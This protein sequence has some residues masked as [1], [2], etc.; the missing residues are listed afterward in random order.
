MKTKRGRLAH[1]FFRLYNKAHEIVT[2]KY[3]D[4]ILYNIRVSLNETFNRKLFWGYREYVKRKKFYV[5]YFTISNG[6]EIFNVLTN[7][8]IYSFTVGIEL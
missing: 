3:F 4:K 1:K 8:K 7:N 2:S 6:Y 5:F